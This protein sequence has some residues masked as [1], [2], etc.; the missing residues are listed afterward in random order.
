[1]KTMKFIPAILAMLSVFSCSNPEQASTPKEAETAS[2]SVHAKPAET[3]ETQTVSPA[4]TT[5]DPAAA[6]AIHGIVGQYLA[7]KNALAS[8]N[9]AQAAEAAG[10]LRDALQKVDKSLLTAEQKTAYDKAEEVIRQQ[11]AQIADAAGDIARQ[12]GSFFPLSESVYA[13]AKQFGGGRTLYH[14]HCPM[15]RDNQGAL[16]ISEQQD[17]RNPY[18]GS[19][20]LTCGTVE[21]V[22]Q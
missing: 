18:F 5:I 9:A 4:F 22:I 16:W 19:G 15:A 8:D 6:A 2:A 10:A 13:L 11:A 17:I 14:D 3:A 12:R 20:M 1:M 21:E 7:V